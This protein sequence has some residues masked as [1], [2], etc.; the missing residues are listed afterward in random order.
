M[1]LLESLCHFKAS[2]LVLARSVNKARQ[3]YRCDR[4]AGLDS[5]DLTPKLLDGATSQLSRAQRLCLVVEGDVAA[6]EGAEGAAGEAAVEAGAVENPLEEAALSAAA[7]A[8]LRREEAAAIAVGVQ[9]RSKAEGAATA[10]KD[11]AM[12]VGRSAAEAQAVAVVAPRK[13]RTSESGTME[14]TTTLSGSAERSGKR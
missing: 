14:T 10:P 4:M 6:H 2:D 8:D 11:A 13:D 3:Y 7:A 1:L 12:T 5:I 9:G